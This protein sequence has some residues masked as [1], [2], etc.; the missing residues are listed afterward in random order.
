MQ[1]QG[2]SVSLR[3]SLYVNASRAETVTEAAKGTGRKRWCA[4][5]VS[6]EHP[7]WAPASSLCRSSGRP[8]G[9]WLSQAAGG[10][11]P[12][13]LGSV[14]VPAAPL[15]GLRSVYTRACRLPCDLL[16]ALSTRSPC[17]CVLGLGCTSTELGLCWATCV[18]SETF[19]GLEVKA[20]L[21]PSYHDEPWGPRRWSRALGGL[22]GWCPAPQGGPGGGMGPSV[23]CQAK[24]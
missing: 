22:P 18:L 5:N 6:P 10:P 11:G 14:L 12:G 3:L 8:P 7:L 17:P 15:G 16:G 19:L 1:K 20:R 13:G 23:A 4:A 24:R 21:G 9:W 2:I